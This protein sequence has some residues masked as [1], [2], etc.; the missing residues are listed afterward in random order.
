MKN[1]NNQN[2]SNNNQSENKNNNLTEIDKK[3]L[4][5]EARLYSQAQMKIPEKKSINKVF[6]YIVLL[7]LLILL[8][9]VLSSILKN[10]ML[11]KAG[12]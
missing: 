12:M 11:L 7:I 3:R 5:E 6:M 10:Y 9:Y 1:N 4:L 8:F 2:V